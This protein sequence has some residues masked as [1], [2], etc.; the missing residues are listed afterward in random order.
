MTTLDFTPKVVNLKCHAGDTAS[1]R[2]FASTAFVAGRVWTAQVRSA[3]GSALVDATLQV[4][5]PTVT[6]GPAYLTLTSA[7]SARLAAMGNGVQVM[8][9]TG[10]GEAP[11]L[12]SGVWDCQVA[13][14]GGGDPTNTVAHGSVTISGDVTR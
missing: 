7:D 1:F 4:V 10:G 14:V 3:S 8:R 11:V 6:D 9:L 5:P 13:P 2:V 12:Y